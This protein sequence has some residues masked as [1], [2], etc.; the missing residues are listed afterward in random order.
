MI[1][2]QENK[3]VSNFQ[4]VEEF[5]SKLNYKDALLWEKVK[6]AM[7]SKKDAVKFMESFYQE[8]ETPK[9][10]VVPEQYKS[11]AKLL[12]IVLEFVKVF[13]NKEWDEKISDI[14]KVL[15][16]FIDTTKKKK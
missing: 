13:T 4:K 1:F 2:G 5:A 7:K 14:Q 10:L 15:Q 9:G 12:I 16:M 6:V 3:T 11:I 8:F